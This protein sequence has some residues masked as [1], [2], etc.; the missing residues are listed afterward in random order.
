[1]TR[2]ALRWPL[3]RRIVGSVSFTCKAM[4]TAVPD[5]ATPP[6]RTVRW[7]NTNQLL[8]T[9]MRG[10]T[11]LGVKTVRQQRLCPTTVAFE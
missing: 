5:G 7:T 6:P 8:R 2:H 4:G 1:M 11:C 10:A 9:R 3:F